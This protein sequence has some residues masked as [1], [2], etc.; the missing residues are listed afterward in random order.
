MQLSM[1]TTTLQSDSPF[2]W[3]SNFVTGNCKFCVMIASFTKKPSGKDYDNKMALP[4]L[5]GG[6]LRVNKGLGGG[7]FSSKTQSILRKTKKEEEGPP[8]PI[9]VEDAET[10]EKL[11]LNEVTVAMRAKE[12]T[13][14]AH[15]KHV[16]SKGLSLEP[17]P[18]EDVLKKAA[19]NRAQLEIVIRQHQDTVIRQLIEREAGKE[20]FRRELLE[21]EKSDERLQSLEEY[22]T[23]DRVAA[24]NLLKTTRM[25][26]E[27]ALAA[28]LKKYFD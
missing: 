13:P 5:A 23:K 11:L 8:P 3:R 12:Q 14:F 4:P 18:P 27:G 26:F 9:E 24:A 21:N 17:L 2:F 6:A 25:M 1:E 20:A 22:F 16:L 15:T 7:N 19:V 28:Q 10:G